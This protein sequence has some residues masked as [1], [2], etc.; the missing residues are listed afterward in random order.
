MKMIPVLVGMNSL[1]LYQKEFPWGGFHF[2]IQSVCSSVRTLWKGLEGVM[3]AISQKAADSDS[4]SF[5]RRPWS[6]LAATRMK[7]PE[8]SEYKASSETQG[9]LVGAGRSL[10]GREKNRAKKSQERLFSRP[11]RLLPAPTN[12]T[13]V[14]EDEY[15]FSYF[16]RD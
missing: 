14:F 5:A 3:R 4:W 13:W 6:Y 15:N 10:N 2:L 11:F 1:C 9:Q 7:I 12:C 8:E 16:L